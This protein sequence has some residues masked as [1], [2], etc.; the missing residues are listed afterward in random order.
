MND[1]RKLME[2][3]EDDPHKAA[4]ND[5]EAYHNSEPNDE[6]EAF[7]YGVQWGNAAQYG[8]GGYGKEELPPAYKEWVE[9]GRKD[10]DS[11]YETMEEDLRGD[12]SMGRVDPDDYNN[13]VKEAFL[14]GYK[15]GWEDCEIERDGGS[16][17]YEAELGYAQWVKHDR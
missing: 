16:G 2:M 8:D 17:G 6:Y 11:M 3:V 9:S 5:A 14:A 15:D 10:Y 1:M 7:V 13:E 12:P 4:Q